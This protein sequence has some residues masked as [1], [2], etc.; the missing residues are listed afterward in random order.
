[1]AGFKGSL[2]PNLLKQE[3]QSLACT[4]RIFFKML[5]DP[6]RERDW[7]QVQERLISV[8]RSGLEYYVTLTETHREAWNILILLILTKIHKMPN[9]QVSFGFNVS[10]TLIENLLGTVCR[11]CKAVLS[12]PLRNYV[13][14]F[15]T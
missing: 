6:A 7:P 10:P 12:F 11:P 9:E 15:E 5:G 4:L 3:V 1:M 8:C 2:K 13:F 14:Q